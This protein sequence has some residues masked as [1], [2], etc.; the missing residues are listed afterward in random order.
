MF[1]GL[2]A[3]W[4]ASSG[5]RGEAPSHKVASETPDYLKRYK[6]LKAA[7]VSIKVFNKVYEVDVRVVPREY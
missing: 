3:I 6:Q 2:D 1:T 7:K 5:M 4:S